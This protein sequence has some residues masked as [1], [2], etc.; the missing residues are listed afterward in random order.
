MAGIEETEQVIAFIKKF[1]E[2]LMDAK[3]DGSI[4]ILDAMKGLSLISPL[5]SAVSG[6][7][8][9]PVEMKD[10]TGEEAEKLIKELQEAVLA[11]ITAIG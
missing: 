7:Y 1:A 8:L 3:A 5:T 2:V 9:I 6:A 4:D 10:L 11:I